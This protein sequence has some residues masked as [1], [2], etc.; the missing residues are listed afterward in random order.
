MPSS[1]P[2]AERW[3]G[4]KDLW[5]AYMRGRGTGDRERSVNGRGPDGS[6]AGH[7]QPADGVGAISPASPPATAAPGAD[8]HGHGAAPDAPTA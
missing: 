6:F 8:R 1:T 2:T 4:S 3:F 7:R 5:W